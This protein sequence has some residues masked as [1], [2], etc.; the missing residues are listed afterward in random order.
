VSAVRSTS[1][2]DRRCELLPLLSPRLS[3]GWSLQHSGVDHRCELLPLLSPRLSQGWSLQH[4]GVDHRCE[5]LLL[6]P[7][8]SAQATHRWHAK[9]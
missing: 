3:Q 9:G 8:A 1:G 2:V 5:L 4:S 7:I 6:S